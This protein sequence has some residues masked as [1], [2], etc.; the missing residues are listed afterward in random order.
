MGSGVFYAV[1]AE[2]L[3]QPVRGCN[4]RTADFQLLVSYKLIVRPGIVLEPRR[5][6]TSAV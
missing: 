2:M 4:Q 5:S 1:G 3:A 6:G